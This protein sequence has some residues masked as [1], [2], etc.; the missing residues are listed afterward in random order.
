MARILNEVHL[1]G[2]DSAARIDLISTKKQGPS[3][4]IVNQDVRSYTKRLAVYLIAA[5][6]V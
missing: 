1:V 6:E 4:P 2:L 5:I 3:Q